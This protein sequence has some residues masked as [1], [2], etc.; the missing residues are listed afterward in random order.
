MKISIHHSVFFIVL[1]LSAIIGMIPAT[2]TAASSDLLISQEGSMMDWT[3]AHI[4]NNIIATY[5]SSSAPP[6]IKVY[7]ADAKP[8]ATVSLPDGTLKALEIAD[9]QLY[10][11]NAEGVFEYTIV[12]GK[13]RLIDSTTEPITKIVADG[14][15]VVMRGG[16]D[17]RKLILHTLSTG[18]NQVIFTSPD[19]IHGLA[20]DGDRIMWGC[21]RVD[22][23]PGREIHVYTISTGTDYIIP[24]SKS[25]RTFGYGDISGNNV[26]W[27]MGAKEPDYINGVPVT[28]ES[29]DIRLTDLTSGKTRSVETSQT[30][31]MV[32]P[33]ISGN[34]VVWVKKPRVD[35]NNTDIGTIRAYDIGTGTFSDH[36]S[37]I[38][39]ISDFDKGQVIWSKFK[40]AS[41]W[42]TTVPG[43]NPS[44]ASP[45]ATRA[46]TGTPVSPQQNPT[47][48]ESP[49]DAVLI[50]LVA[51]LSVMVYVILKKARAR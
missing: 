24:E 21:E 46:E 9:G 39:G 12:T 31:P 6:E 43:G 35:Y 32:V 22:G 36:A 47:P 1:I 15:H 34:T 44:V 23:E 45:T 50:G 27:S 16:V 29:Y 8:Y 49:V 11:A 20:I 38:D 30:A 5:V 17:D 28:L 18:S 13:T 3:D 14:D 2:C 33:F 41:F 19:W 4:D 25:V 37:E 42:L 10:Y 51:G 40:P 26:V 48:A 7:T